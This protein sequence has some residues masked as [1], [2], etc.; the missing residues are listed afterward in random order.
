[1]RT[2]CY[3]TRQL[4]FFESPL[5]RC[6]Q[7]P[8][9]RPS[10]SAVL[11]GKPLVVGEFRP[12]REVQQVHGEDEGHGALVLGLRMQLVLRPGSGGVALLLH[13]Q[14]DGLGS[15]LGGAHVDGDVD[16]TVVDMFDGLEDARLRLGRD[17]EFSLEV[18]AEKL[19]ELRVRLVV[20]HFFLERVTS[21]GSN[22]EDL[23]E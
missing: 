22:Y 2:A 1:M 23:K 11:D 17:I 15:V 16:A 14:V 20:G 4:T 19:K 3:E 13:L 5:K 8:I 6:D 7:A 9:P 21:P 10:L 18:L 12:E